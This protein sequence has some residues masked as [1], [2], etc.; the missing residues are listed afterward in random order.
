MNKQTRH[1]KSRAVSGGAAGAGRA[2]YG[3]RPYY[4]PN[5]NKCQVWQID[6][7]LAE[8]TRLRQAE[9]LAYARGFVAGWLERGGE[10]ER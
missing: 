10:G 1:K 7:L 6:D 8:L 3:L 9:R 2:S 5:P 4:R